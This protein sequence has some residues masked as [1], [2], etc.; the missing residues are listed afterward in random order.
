MAKA[1]AYLCRQCCFIDG[2]GEFGEFGGVSIHRAESWV[3]MHLMISLPG[4]LPQP[5][6]NL[7]V[8]LGVMAD[9][10]MV[11]LYYHGKPENSYH[12]MWRLPQHIHQSDLKFR[13]SSSWDGGNKKDAKICGSSSILFVSASRTGDTGPNQWLGSWFLVGAGKQNWYGLR[14][15]QRVPVPLPEVFRDDTAF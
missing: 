5:W 3:I 4:H 8:S 9:V 2:F 1:C 7:L 14:R 12:G 11:W 15:D 10:W 6:R 13:R